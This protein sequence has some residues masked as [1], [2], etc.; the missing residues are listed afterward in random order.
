MTTEQL[1]REMFLLV[2][3]TFGRRSSQ[4]EKITCRKDLRQGQVGHVQE[5]A[6]NPERATVVG[7]KMRETAGRQ[8]IRDPQAIIRTFPLSDVGSHGEV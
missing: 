1:L 2:M 8:I 6:D 3:W 4:A 5:R 7:E